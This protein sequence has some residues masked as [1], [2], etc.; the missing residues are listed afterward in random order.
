MGAGDAYRG[1]LLWAL[2]RGTGSRRG[3]PHGERCRRDEVESRGTQDYALSEP[4]MRER[5]GLCPRRVVLNLRPQ[6]G[7]QEADGLNG[8]LRTG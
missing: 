4:L 3:R 6:E 7:I 1:G 5:P 2:A 8:K